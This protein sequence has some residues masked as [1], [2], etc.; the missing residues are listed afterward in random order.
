MANNLKKFATEA[1]YNSATLNTPA[2]SWVTATDNV[3]F[4]Y[5]ATPIPPAPP[6]Q[7]V[8]ADDEFDLSTPIYAIDAEDFSMEGGECHAYLSDGS[9]NTYL[10]QANSNANAAALELNGQTV[11]VNLNSRKIDI[12]NTLGH[13]L[14]L[15]AA[16]YYTECTDW[17]CPDECS[18]CVTWYDSES[19][20][21][22]DWDTGEFC[23]EE[24][25]NCEE[26]CVQEYYGYICRV[27]VPLSSN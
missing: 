24:I 19:G 13:P 11:G 22:V 17:S 26:E 18:E 2:V 14:Y 7:T 21:C 16:P 3:H 27:D 6:L 20:E 25:C 12:Y 1:D 15:N 8:Q 10:Y 9:G 23:C 5:N 4:D